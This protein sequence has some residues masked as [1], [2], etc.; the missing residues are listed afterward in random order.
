MNH[1]EL[2][3]DMRTMGARGQCAADGPLARKVARLSPGKRLRSGAEYKKHPPAA[4]P[5]EDNVVVISSD[6]EEQEQRQPL[7]AVVPAP[8]PAD[9]GKRSYEELEAENKDLKNQLERLK[10]AH[11][12]LIE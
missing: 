12:A 5:S 9:A 7:P 2:R 3:Y 8:A 4:E 1:C 6:D 10:A 11:R